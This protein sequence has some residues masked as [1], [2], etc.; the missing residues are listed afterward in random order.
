VK[1][2]YFIDWFSPGY[3][4]GG[5]IQS[6]M[7]LIQSLGSEVTFSIVTD[8]RDFGDKTAYNIKLNEW[9]VWNDHQVIYLDRQHQKLDFYRSLYQDVVPDI[10]HINGIFSRAFSI[11]P[12]RMANSLNVKSRVIISIRGMLHYEALRQKAWKKVP[13]LM[14]AKL[15][16]KFKKVHWHCTSEEEVKFLAKKMGE[17][18]DYSV[19]PN[20]GF[21][22]QN[23]PK[24]LK[25]DQFSLRLIF[26]GRIH[27]IK[28]LKKALL[29]LNEIS[30]FNIQYTIIGHLEDKEYWNDCQSVI[31]NLPKNIQCQYT[32]SLPPREVRESIANHHALLLPTESENFGHAIFECFALGRLAII[33]ENTPWRN[34]EEK[35]IGYD[36]D[37]NRKDELISAIRKV[38]RMNQ[39]DFDSA[40]RRC[41]NFALQFHSKTQLKT[42]YLK[43][44]KEVINQS[45]NLSTT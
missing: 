4:A 5:P 36:I 2:L 34:L 16:G 17:G 43:M 20:I 44:Y 37:N 30:S 7:N 32:G 45:K 38:G 14:L 13:F 42:G 31:K 1:I 19:L 25:K 15:L 12:L 22:P 26:V 21:Y 18:L 28:G 27:P 41:H 6:S 40:S 10:I 23:G 29:A 3:K 8:D 11:L 39:E 9:Q 24:R 35:G 33:S